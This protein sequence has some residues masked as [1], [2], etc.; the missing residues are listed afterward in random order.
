[1]VEEEDEEE[2]EAE[3]A[4]EKAKEEENSSSF[5]ISINQ[6]C[7]SLSTNLHKK[8]HFTHHYCIPP[9]RKNFEAI[10]TLLPQ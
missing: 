2:E 8:L 9:N 3:E 6:P 4:E 10:M 5:L 1:M 7:I